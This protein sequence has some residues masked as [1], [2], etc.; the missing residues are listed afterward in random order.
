MGIFVL[1]NLSVGG[2]LGTTGVEG[3][4]P[5]SGNTNSVEEIYKVVGA[6]LYS[7]KPGNVPGDIHPFVQAGYA[8]YDI[9]YGGAGGDPDVTGTGVFGGAG[10]LYTIRRTFGIYL[11]GHVLTS[12]FD[13]DHVVFDRVQA[14]VSA[15][16][17]VIF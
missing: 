9:F 4:D 17:T 15:G 11:A 13:E 14:E 12:S 6:T 5:T 7:G 8:W 16:A 10:F 2:F 3:T 1:P